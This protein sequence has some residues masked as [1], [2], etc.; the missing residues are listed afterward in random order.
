V[1]DFVDTMMCVV[2]GSSFIVVGG[3][4]VAVVVVSLIFSLGR[5]SDS[6]ASTWTT[7]DGVPDGLGRIATRFWGSRTCS[8][9][10]SVL[11]WIV[12]MLKFMDR[13]FTKQRRCRLRDCA[14]SRPRVLQ[15]VFSAMVTFLSAG[16]RRRAIKLIPPGLSDWGTVC[17]PH[18]YRFSLAF[19]CCPLHFAQGWWA[20]VW[21][22]W[23]MCPV[24]LG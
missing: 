16:A 6:V 15:S 1:P 20:G 8:L 2:L 19:G 13:V 4:G 3:G 22:I 12:A 23:H 10:S 17:V 5:G 7:R 9:P 18:Y 24:S 21:M 11:I 14:I